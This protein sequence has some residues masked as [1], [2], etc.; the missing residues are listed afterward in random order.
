MSSFH[1]TP[2][3]VDFELRD[4]NGN[5]HRKRI[6]PWSKSTLFSCSLSTIKVSLTRVYEILV[7]VDYIHRFVLQFHD[8]SNC[9]KESSNAICS[10]CFLFDLLEFLEAE[11]YLTSQGSSS[12]VIW[13]F[14]QVR[15]IIKNISLEWAQCEVLVL[16]PIHNTNSDGWTKTQ[17]IILQ[18]NL[19]LIH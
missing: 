10:C 12:G 15:N 9:F 2:Y 7:N 13:N 19:T 11:V 16:R 6:S 14:I 5:T 1:Q 3:S 4:N 17:L 8:G 18:I